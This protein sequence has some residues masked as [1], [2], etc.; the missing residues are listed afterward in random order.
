MA[1]I[2]NVQKIQS[3]LKALTSVRSSTLDTLKFLSNS[4]HPSATILNDNQQQQQQ[5]N[6]QESDSY[7]R[8]FTSLLNT[9]ENKVRDL[10]TVC[11]LLYPFINS[12]DLANSRMIA[13]DPNYEKTSLYQDMIISYRWMDNVQEYSTL[14]IQAL[15]SKFFKKNRHRLRNSNRTNLN[16]NIN[17]M[18]VDQF[19]GQLQRTFD[20][21]LIELRRPFGVFSVL[22]IELD[23]TLRAM[24]VLRGLVIEWVL[25]KSFEE[26]FEKLNQN[27]LFDTNFSNNQASSN[28]QFLGSG[29]IHDSGSITNETQLKNMDIWQPSRYQI[30]RTITDHAN[31]A[32]LHFYSPFQMENAIKAYLIWF[33]GYS[34]LFSAVCRKCDA[35]LLNNMPP[36]WR[37]FRSND[38]YHFEC[39]P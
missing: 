9:L 8:E 6:S 18:V 28:K 31:A 32:I 37:D 36:T 14:A 19:I 26:N 22:K 30:F 33:R 35:R 1:D 3:A 25:V 11:T 7:L 34:N 13:Q 20:P 10:E 24:I 29:S 15:Q 5:Q 23:R 4:F 27:Y 2:N 17:L 12:I 38:P 16:H 21:M 39:R